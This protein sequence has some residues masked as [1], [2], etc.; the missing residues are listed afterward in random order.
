MNH[1]G[2]EQE[3]VPA[4]GLFP[5]LDT[6]T[7]EMPE[8]ALWQRIRSTRSAQR[9]RRQRIRGSAIGLGGILVGAGLM[10]ALN[11]PPDVDA[12]AMAEQPPAP[13]ASALAGSAVRAID[14]RLQAAYDRN[15]HPDEIR[16]LWQLRD[17]T[18]TGS[19]QAGA[20]TTTVLEL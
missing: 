14:R 16:R 3:S 13:P 6:R 12:P 8:E 20:V 15:A 9:R 17:A 19:D 10:L 18:V 11:A 1:K 7:V 5:A 4:A 2:C